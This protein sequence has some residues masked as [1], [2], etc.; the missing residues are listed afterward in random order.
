MKI[1]EDQFMDI[2]TGMVSL[3]LEYVQ[4]QADEIFIY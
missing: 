4:G 3:A 2:Q 1:F